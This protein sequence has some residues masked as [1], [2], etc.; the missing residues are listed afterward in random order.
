[1][2]EVRNSVVFLT[3]LQSQ[4]FG[5]FS[6]SATNL[7]FSSFPQ[8]VVR[9]SIDLT[10]QVISLTGLKLTPPVEPSAG[11]KNPVKP[12]KTLQKTRTAGER[13]L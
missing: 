2:V 3:K 5:G 12:A 6:D 10:L 11:V 8:T 7:D 9:K 13:S 1:M 4:I